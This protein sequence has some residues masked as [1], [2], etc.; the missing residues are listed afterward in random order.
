MSFTPTYRARRE[1]KG[2]PKFPYYRV[3]EYG[4]PIA[5]V[6]VDPTNAARIFAKSNATE[7]TLSRKADANSDWEVVLSS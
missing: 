4:N 6:E 7:K 2:N 5:Y 1:Q 3:C